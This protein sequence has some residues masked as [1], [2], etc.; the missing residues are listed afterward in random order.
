[1]GSHTVDPKKSKGAGEGSLYIVAT[2]PRPNY[3]KK[4]LVCGA[5]Y[6]A[7]TLDFSKGITFGKYEK[8]TLEILAKRKAVRREVAEIRRQ[9]VNKIKMNREDTGISH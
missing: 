2:N 9:K 5:K 4:E 1:M 6:E 3:K 7:T 8:N